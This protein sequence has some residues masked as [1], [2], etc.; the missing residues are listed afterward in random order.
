MLDTIVSLLN[1]LGSAPRPLWA[2]LGG[3]LVS[4]GVTQRLKD[5]VPPHWHG[6]TADVAV[7]AIAFVAGALA[8]VGLWSIAGAASLSTAVTAALIVG[9]WSPAAWDILTMFI[10]WKWPRLRFDLTRCGRRIN[11]KP[12]DTTP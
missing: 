3:T 11:K 7:R 10:G 4:W 12:E 1:A 8:T 9:L 5:Y 6:N 2:M